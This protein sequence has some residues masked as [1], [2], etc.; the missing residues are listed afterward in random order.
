LIEKR[1]RRTGKSVKD[2]E[3]VGAV[4]EITEMR[5]PSDYAHFRTSMCDD[6]QESET[7]KLRPYQEELAEAAL[8]GKNTIACAPTGSGKTEVAIHVATSHLDERAENRQPARVAMLVPRTPLVDQQK[9]RFHKYVRGKYYVEGFH[10][11]GL[12]GASRRDIVLAC[13]IVVMTPQILLNMLKS[14]RQDE[15]LYVCDFS[16][17]IFDEVHHCTK[18]H[19]YNILMQ[20]I[21]DYQGPKPQHTLLCRGLPAR[22]Q[23]VII[24]MKVVTWEIQLF[25]AVPSYNQISHSMGR[26]IEWSEYCGVE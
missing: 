11:S 26:L 9:H 10:G 7:L 8:R 6:V 20:T 3:F 19:P 21:H 5:K 4:P 22:P 25:S 18:D 13:D 15:R 17:L 14:I 16:L 12:K 2:D 1:R 23:N 24:M